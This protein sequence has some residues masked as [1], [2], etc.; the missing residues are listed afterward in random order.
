MYFKYTYTYILKHNIYNTRARPKNYI[1]INN[2]IYTESA[3]GRSHRGIFRVRRKYGPDVTAIWGERAGLSRLF[4]FLE[5]QIF[6]RF[7]A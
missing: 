1:Y 3:G 2:E 5:H 7:Y 4:F 6:C